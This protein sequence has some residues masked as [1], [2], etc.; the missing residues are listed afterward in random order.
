MAFVLTILIGLL[1]VCEWSV[2]D[3]TNDV[4]GGRLLSRCPRGCSCSG[5][6]TDC[7]HRGLTQVPKSIPLDTE[8]L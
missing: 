1:I 6:T 7:S 5:T 4:S 8:R 2:A 3:Q